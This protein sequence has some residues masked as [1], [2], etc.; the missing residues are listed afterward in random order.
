MK[1]AYI[2]D[3]HID[4]GPL[5]RSAARLLPEAVEEAAPDVFI[6]GGDIAS[7]LSIIDHTLASFCDLTIPKL[8]VPGNHDIW[9]SSIK[10]KEEG[11][12]SRDK[13]RRLIPE[14]C[15]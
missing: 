2:S 9:I 8:Y 12:T 5:G 1:L 13:Y 4:A 7:K 3:L 15:E 11:V 10:E 14:V 6:I